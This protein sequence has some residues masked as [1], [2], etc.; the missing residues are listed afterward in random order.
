MRCCSMASSEIS[1]ATPS[2]IPSP[3]VGFSSAVA[4][5][6]ERHASTFA[7]RASVSRVSNCR[8]SLRRLLDLIPRGVMDSVSDYSSCAGPSKCSDIASISALSPPEDHASPYSQREPTRGATSS[9]RAEAR[10]NGN[11]DPEMEHRMNFVINPAQKPSHLNR[12]QALQT[13]A[14]ATAAAGGLTG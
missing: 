1:S 9:R 7:T 10:S 8:E 12:R 13:V 3:K 11:D 6:A 4:V 14:I 5:R 2:N